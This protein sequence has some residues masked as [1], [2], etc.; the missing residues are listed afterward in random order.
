MAEEGRGDRHA[1]RTDEEAL[2]LSEARKAAML[3]AALDA[4]VCIDRDGVVLEFSVAAERMF[5]RPREAMLGA[6]LADAV[7]PPE[8]RDRHRDGLRRASERPEH[9]PFLRRRL[10]LEGLRADG[11]RFPLELMVVPVVVD[12]HPRLFTA[13]VRDL[14]DRRASERALRDGEARVRALVTHAPMVLWA[15]DADGRVTLAEGRRLDALGLP[16]ETV[17]AD[18]TLA[19]LL[20]GAPGLLAASERALAGEPTHCTVRVDDAVFEAQVA[21]FGAG[22]DAGAVGVATDVTERF[23]DAERLA[24]LAYHDTVT[25]LPNRVLVAEHLDAAL[26]RAERA[27][28]A[29]AVLFIDLDDFK[30]VND[31]LGHAAGD[32]LL[33]AVAERLAGEVRGTDV[34]A[35]HG[36]DE[37]I[38]LL[39]DLDPERCDDAVDV[40]ARKVLAALEAPFDVGGTGLR[41]GASVGA[42]VAPGDGASADVL[43]RRADHAMYDA[44]QGARGGLSRYRRP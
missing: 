8:L 42:A 36:G 14:S 4:V 11:T 1:L 43:L 13:Y 9:G 31:S 15:A 30:R 44:K 22:P 7:I 26:A 6:P 20:A 24:H 10:E 32:E 37:F 17:V 5:G 19:E 41:V 27:S 23:R 34:V 12:D 21:P 35:R 18:L 16:P 40:V 33:R 28:V 3:D 29:V 2:R 38:V 39:A 25:G